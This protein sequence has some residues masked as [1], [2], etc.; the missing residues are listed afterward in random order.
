MSHVWVL[1]RHIQGCCSSHSFEGIPLEVVCIAVRSLEHCYLFFFFMNF[2]CAIRLVII[3]SEEIE[4]TANSL[5][6]HIETHHGLILR[7]LTVNSQED[8][9]CELAGSFS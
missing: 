1:P 4:L 5:G 8:S 6:A 3:S 7:T 9:P 2:I